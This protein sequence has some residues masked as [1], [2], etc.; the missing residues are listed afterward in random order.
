MFNVKND[1]DIK[2]SCISQKLI[3]SCLLNV[4][5]MQKYD[6]GRNSIIK[7]DKRRNAI[8]IENIQTNFLFFLKFRI[9]DQYT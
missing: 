5:D 8:I 7:G 4:V 3:L 6:K 2:S 9:S 1:L